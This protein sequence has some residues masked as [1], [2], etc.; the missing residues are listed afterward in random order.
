MKKTYYILI[1]IAILFLGFLVFQ[2][3]GYSFLKENIERTQ[4]AVNEYLEAGCM[5]PSDSTLENPAPVNFQLL[6][7]YFEKDLEF[8]K[9]AKYWLTKTNEV[10]ASTIDAP[11]VEQGDSLL[12]WNKVT[13]AE[14]YNIYKIKDDS[15]EIIKE[16]TD[17]SYSC[18]NC[19]VSAV[20]K[21]GYETAPV[22]ENYDGYPNQSPVA[23]LKEGQEIKENSGGSFA[24]VQQIWTPSIEE[25]AADAD[26]AKITD[27]Q[28]RKEDDDITEIKS[29]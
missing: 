6:S 23:L 5:I 27:Y 4:A 24:W 9:P 26:G 10:F 3:Q 19:L 18:S 14:K 2:N 7:G 28:T 29:K 16:T 1:I 12:T 22:G 17:T 15:Y 8:K 20:D 13:D 25:L 21:Y 11:D